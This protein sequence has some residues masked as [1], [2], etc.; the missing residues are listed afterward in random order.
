MEGRQDQIRAMRGLLAALLSLA[1]VLAIAA[2]GGGDSSDGGDGGTSEGTTASAPAITKAE[3]IKKADAICRKTD[4]IQKKALK[5]Y[6]GGEKLTLEDS[7]EMRKLMKVVLLPP[8][9]A[10]LKQIA[11]LG[12]PAGEEAK[13]TA[14][15]TGWERALEKSLK[16]PSLLIGFDDGPFIAPG[17]LAAKYGFKDCD[18][19]I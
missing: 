11:A 18:Q 8:I 19:V 10:E 2:C 14:I 9:E 7:P 3:L 5:A 4:E 6:P 15:M 16:D 12:A 17:K 13:V 1:L